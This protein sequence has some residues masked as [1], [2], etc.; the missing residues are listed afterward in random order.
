MWNRII[1]PINGK[2][3]SVNDN[4]G[5]KI[6]K[7]YIYHLTGGTDTATAATVNDSEYS[8]DPDHETIYELKEIQDAMKEDA[9][10]KIK[11]KTTMD[12][13]QKK[14]KLE[15]SRE[16]CVENEHCENGAFCEKH[17]CYKGGSQNIDIVEKDTPDPPPPTDEED[18][19]PTDEKDTTQT[20]N[21]ILD[22]SCKVENVRIALEIKCGDKCLVNITPDS[23]PDDFRPIVE[24]IQNILSGENG[25][26]KSYFDELVQESVGCPVTVV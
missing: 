22:H 13:E 2:Y 6:L 5:K 10:K 25:D 8:E 19:P 17:N 21:A 14:R 20:V 9:S 24:N 23:V 15:A 18:T 4:L 26:G 7:N 1:N 12:P 3:V 11:L 16:A